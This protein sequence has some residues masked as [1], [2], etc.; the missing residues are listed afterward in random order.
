MY[1]SHTPIPDEWK[2]E[3]T[4]Y[5]A[6]HA[7]ADGG[8]GLH[9]ESRSTVFATGLYYVVLRILG[10]DKNHALARKGRE[11]LLSLGGT[12]GIP[13]WGKIWLACLNLFDWNG[14]NCIPVDLWL[15]PAW[16]PFHPSRWW[17][18]CR[19]V[20]LPTSYL[21]SNRCTIPLTPLL[22]E[23]REEIYTT[24]YASIKFS[25]Y[26]NHTAKTDA[27]RKISPLLIFLFTILSF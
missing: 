8:W 20:Y 23:I 25:D 18:Q 15:L 19:V 2:I 4:R 5:L 1:I 7:N 22:A 14:V 9:L 21:W 26:R 17:V 10:M 24:P 6:N 13:Q 11:C 27:V 3:M 12:A 16:L